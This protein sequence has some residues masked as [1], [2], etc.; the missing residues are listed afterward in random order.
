MC[1]GSRT[2]GGFYILYCRSICRKDCNKCGGCRVLM[3]VWAIAYGA[4]VLEIAGAARSGES[5]RLLTHARAWLC[6]SYS[7]HMLTVPAVERLSEAVSCVVFLQGGCSF[8]I[9]RARRV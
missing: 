2:L 4:R 1:Q 8:A 7:D 9:G 5:R 6:L 3:R